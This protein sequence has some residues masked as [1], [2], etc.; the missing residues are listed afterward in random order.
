MS[1]LVNRQIEFSRKIASLIAHAYT[2][3]YGI[4]LG[5]AYRDPR[6]FGDTSESIGYGH[7]NSNH[8]RRLAIDLNIFIDG[9]YITD[10]LPYKKLHSFWKLLGGSMIEND[11]NHFSIKYKGQI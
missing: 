5:D 2:L 8:K 11:L 9:E 7:A 10:N 1:E 3:G 4:T 6:V